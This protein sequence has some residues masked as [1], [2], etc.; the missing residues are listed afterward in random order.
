MKVVNKEK[1]LERLSELLKNIELKSFFKKNGT[2]NI[3][4]K[5]VVIV[6][7]IPEEKL[8][9][10]ILSELSAT[11]NRISCKVDEYQSLTKANCE[12]LQ[13]ELFKV[14]EEPKSLSDLSEKNRSMLEDSQYPIIKKNQGI[15][16]SPITIIE[17]LPGD[18]DNK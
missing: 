6:D 1:K 2:S 13:L 5:K 17:S 8:A 14:D 12:Q 4:F 11:F 15:A 10:Y 3:K 9:E 7:E 16:G 18:S